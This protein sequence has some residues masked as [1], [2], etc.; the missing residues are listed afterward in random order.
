MPTRLLPNQEKKVPTPFCIERSTY[1]KFATMCANT[2]IGK[3]P[4]GDPRV[5]NASREIRLFI[6]NFL[7]KHERQNEK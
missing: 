4:N 5:S 2:I 3:K 6:I 7:K 1:D